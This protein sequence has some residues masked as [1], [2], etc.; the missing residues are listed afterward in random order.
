MKKVVGILLTA[1]MLTGN[2]AMPFTAVAADAAADEV[3]N[4][5][6][7]ETYCKNMEIDEFYNLPNKPL[8][9]DIHDYEDF[10]LE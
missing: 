1:A 6:T 10:T 8:T 5:A 4:T 9:V 7:S 3:K 2:A